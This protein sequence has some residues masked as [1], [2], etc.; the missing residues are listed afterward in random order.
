MRRALAA[1]VLGISLWLGSLAWSGF[2][3]TR[4]VLDPGRSETVADAL[5]DDDDVRDRLAGNLAAAVGAAL[6]DGAPVDDEQLRVG[7][8][9]A[10]AR[11]EVEA[12]LRSAFVDTHQAFLGE[13]EPPQS[14]TIEVDGIPPV[15]VP[16]PTERVPDLGGVRDA[17]DT[18][19]PLLAG[20]AV[21][22]IAL[23]FAV[24]SDRPAVLRRAGFWAIGLSLF[25]LAVAYGLPWLATEYAPE[26]AE[27]VAALVGAMAGAT[28]G[29]G[30][31]LAASGLVALLV[32]VIWRS[33]PT[34]APAVRPTGRQR[35]P[36]PTPRPEPAPRTRRAARSHERLA[37]TRRVTPPVRPS[38]PPPVTRQPPEP[39]VEQPAPSVLDPTSPPT[40]PTRVQPSAVAP[41]GTRWV[42]G[43]GWVHEGDGPLP[44]GARWVAGVGYVV[45]PD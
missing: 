40:S 39:T 7:A 43:V 14:A 15:V 4:T 19:V 24:T 22:G 37:P 9:E 13:G 20:I 12:V 16:L 41:Q 31:L 10:L 27:V 30:L 35:P 44:E 29:P 23:A 21:L 2:I 18:A 25:V 32:S 45:D 38:S 17:L 5:L 28:R 42:E 11:P 33:A 8:E 1:A 3:L 6:P 26:Q 34:P 36:A